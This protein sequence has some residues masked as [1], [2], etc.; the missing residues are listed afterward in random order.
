MCVIH[1]HPR[2]ASVIGSFFRVLLRYGWI[3][4]MFFVY[5][6]PPQAHMVVRDGRS[7]P[8]P[9]AIT[10][11][12]V[13]EKGAK[14][15]FP[16]VKLP[17]PE[18]PDIK[19]PKIEIPNIELPNLHLPNVAKAP[20]VVQAAQSIEKIIETIQTDPEREELFTHYGWLIFMIFD[21]FQ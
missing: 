8:E 1:F 18:L 20:I 16:S 11:R 9:E 14:L 3:P 19:L 7:V 5:M 17:K 13:T 15:T 12:I 10:A 21:D 2:V 6:F 4:C